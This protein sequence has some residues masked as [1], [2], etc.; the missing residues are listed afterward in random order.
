M[1]ELTRDELRG[2][3]VMA[4]GTIDY[5]NIKENI[6]LIPAD[7]PEA[8]DQ[9]LRIGEYGM[10]SLYK[11]P[12]QDVH[13]EDVNE[14][15]PILTLS[16]QQIC[17]ITP[18]MELSDDDT[19]WSF[20]GSIDNSKNQAQTAYIQVTVDGSPVGDPKSIDIQS[21]EQ[22]RIFFF[23]GQLGVVVPSGTAVGMSMYADQANNLQLGDLL[24]PTKFKITKAQAA[25]VLISNEPIGISQ[26]I[27]FGRGANKKTLH[28]LDGL[29]VG[30]S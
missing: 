11:A 17:E 23:S 13:W 25:P 3:D 29:I 15:E 1:A 28:I 27:T 16:L 21:D 18:D 4:S 5:A 8:I 30:V 14:D 12:D 10:L 22:D 26:D 7:V 2:N 20:S 9:F 24:S 19:T 6:R